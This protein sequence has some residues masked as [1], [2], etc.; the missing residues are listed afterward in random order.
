M[1]EIA[2]NPGLTSAGADRASDWTG[3]SGII[4]SLGVMLGGANSDPGQ[5]G[6]GKPGTATV[7][8]TLLDGVGPSSSW[9]GLFWGIVI[10]V[11][12]L[13]LGKKLT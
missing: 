4:N 12:V 11:G 6:S 7:A 3:G 1:S 13:T 2:Y 10:V 9:K 5:P 8:P